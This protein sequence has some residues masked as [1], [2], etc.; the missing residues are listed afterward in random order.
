MKREFGNFID[1]DYTLEDKADKS[2]P[3]HMTINLV[4]GDV[5]VMIENQ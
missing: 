2:K 5:E 3:V 1:E 4:N